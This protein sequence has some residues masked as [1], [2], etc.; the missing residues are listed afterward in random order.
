[1]AGN[2]L[3]LKGE[4]LVR[5]E[6]TPR[7]GEMREEER[8]VWMTSLK[9]LNADTPQLREPIDFQVYKEINSFTSYSI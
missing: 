7:K 3:L 9:C 5:M 1:M 6:S 2:L 4:R 8:M